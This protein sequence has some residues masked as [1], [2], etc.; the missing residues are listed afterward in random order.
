MLN[1]NDYI[2]VFTWP[3]PF[4]SATFMHMNTYKV[5]GVLKSTQSFSHFV[6]LIDLIEA[7]HFLRWVVGSADPK[8]TLH[9]HMI[10]PNLR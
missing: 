3:P 9:A 2:D 8:G 5:G 1:P 4:P 6:L 10:N 7:N